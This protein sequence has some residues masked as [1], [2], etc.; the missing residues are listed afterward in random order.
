MIY[1]LHSSREIQTTKNL[2][3][4]MRKNWRETH[5]RKHD[6]I[7]PNFTLIYRASI[8][9]YLRACKHFSTFSLIAG[10][11]LGVYSY[12]SEADVS[13]INFKLGPLVTDK[14]ELY[15]FIGAFLLVNLV[16]R[17]TMYK[18]P[19]RIYK[20]AKEYV[21]VFHEAIPF[22]KHRLFFNAGDVTQAPIKGILP[23]RETR[24]Y[25]TNRRCILIPD[26]FR[27]SSELF[28]MLKK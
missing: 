27:S 11:G 2:N 3:F 25:L 20:N 5:Y 17:V 28:S 12:L 6:S 24:Y 15:V 10:C 7:P 16:I 13:T 4:L 23:W 14:T 22:L 8:D 26:G 19:I 9:N 18:L 1:F 21:A